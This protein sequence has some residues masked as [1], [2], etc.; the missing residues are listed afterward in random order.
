MIHS[1]TEHSLLETVSG[2]GKG[3]MSL[4]MFF[5]R[6]GGIAIGFVFYLRFKLQETVD[7][8]AVSLPTR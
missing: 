5:R 6:Y 8:K 1:N 2:G 4:K 3:H 7:S